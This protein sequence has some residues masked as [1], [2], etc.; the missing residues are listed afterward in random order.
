MQ[1]GDREQR[2]RVTGM[3]S[4]ITFYLT[5][6]SPHSPRR[7]YDLLRTKSPRSAVLPAGTRKAASSFIPI[8]SNP[9]LRNESS[10][11]RR[12]R[13]RTHTRCLWPIL[14]TLS[15][16]SAWRAVWSSTVTPLP[17]FSDSK[18]DILPRTFPPNQSAWRRR[19]ALWCLTYMQNRAVDVEG[20]LLGMARTRREL[21]HLLALCRRVRVPRKLRPCTTP[22]CQTCSLKSPR[23]D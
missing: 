7:A 15:R 6:S 21:P 4:G 10:S 16:T 17:A 12:R 5:Q 19:L 18:V 22:N 1:I 8:T 3:M 2:H 9:S 20:G 14:Y 13:T 11:S 23:N